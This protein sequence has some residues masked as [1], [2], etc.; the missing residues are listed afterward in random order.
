MNG[1]GCSPASAVLTRRTKWEKFIRDVITL[2][3]LHHGLLLTH[4]KFKTF[5]IFEKKS[6]ADQ[7]ILRKMR[8]V[9]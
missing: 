5:F 8:K 9:R 6:K 2:K 1:G 3:K 4:E 7:N